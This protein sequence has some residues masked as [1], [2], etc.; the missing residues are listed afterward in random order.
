MDDVLKRKEQ[1]DILEI[2]KLRRQLLF[3]SLLWDQR[4]VCIAKSLKRLPFDKNSEVVEKQNSFTTRSESTGGRDSKSTLFTSISLSEDSVSG[5]SCL[6]SRRT[7]SDGHF[8]KL[9]NINDVLDAR[10]T[11]NSDS[12]CNS[13]T[14]P[15]TK[16]ST[17]ANG[18]LTASTQIIIP[19]SKLHESQNKMFN[20]LHAYMPVYITAPEW[21]GGPGGPRFF[22]PVGVNDIVV[23]V[24]EN[25]P[26]SV[27]SYALSS[28]EYHDKLLNSNHH[29]P[30]PRI[31]IPLPQTPG[32]ILVES[33]RR[34]HLMINFADDGPEGKMYY[35]VVCYYAKYFDRLRKKSSISEQDFIRSLSRCK[36]WKAHGGK[37]KV[38]F[39]KSLDDRFVIKQVTRIEL[40][41]F[42]QFGPAYFKYVSDSIG[43][44]SPTCLAKIYGIYQVIHILDTFCKKNDERCLN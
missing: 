23:P 7:M 15:L 4:L 44:N 41:S 36:N 5:E 26:T 43:S 16:E 33:S 29:E 38:F 2:N 30:T 9:N 21:L 20:P 19:F 22:L 40:E 42:L 32:N 25:E 31:D 14:L 13:D 8:P 18:L 17:E 24:F 10:W 11:G 37:S 34:T 12:S 35:S 6:I 3:C 39:A 28:K 27:I 1:Y